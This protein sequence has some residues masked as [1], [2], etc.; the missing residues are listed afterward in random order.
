MGYFFNW[1]YGHIVARRP[2]RRFTAFL[3]YPDDGFGVAVVS[4]D[5]YQ[6]P[7]SVPTK[8]WIMVRDPCYFT[9][10]SATVKAVIK[11]RR[12]WDGIISRQIS[13]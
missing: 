8:R 2:R 5:I 1:G 9:A 10:F 7:H 3:T 4:I 11:Y 6:A 12:G 13:I